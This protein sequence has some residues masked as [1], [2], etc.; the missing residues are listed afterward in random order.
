MATVFEYLEWRADVPLYTY[1]F[2]E[3]DNLI[4]A[5][6][7]YT[8]FS[9]IVPGDGTWVSLKDA[10]EMFFAV[11]D[12]ESVRA[13]KSCTA[14]AALLMDGMLTGDRFGNMFLSHCLNEFDPEKEL[15]LAAVTFHLNDRTTYVAFRGTD[16]TLVGWKDNF[17]MSVVNGTGGQLMAVDYL[18]WVARDTAGPLIV[19]GHSKG[20]NLAVFASAFCRDETK[21]RIGRVYTNDGP[22]FREEI[23]D[24]AEY[25]AILP[26][27]IGIVPENSV[28]GRLLEDG[29]EHRV[30][31]SSASGI[32]QHDG[33]TWQVKRDRFES[34]ERSPASDLIDRTMDNFIGGM[35]DGSRA[36]LTETVFGILG[37]TGS[38]TVSGVGAQG[39][40]SVEAIANAIR[41]MPREKQ[42]EAL[43]LLKRLGISGGQAAIGYLTDLFTKKNGPS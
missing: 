1:P 13:S 29:Y 33:L 14:K 10:A 19:G 28:V 35:D 8:D 20:G 3:V 38:R 11:H 2:N 42:Q 18:E 21:N 43:D 4:L 24:T 30:V 34:A 31:R 16:G 27:V 5:E 26:K 41:T 6:L 7:A 9:G 17:N 39:L 25:R 23:A 37:S 12:R 22:G 15:Q 40:K 32:L 36:S